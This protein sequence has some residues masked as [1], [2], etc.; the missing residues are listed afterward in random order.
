MMTV[1]TSDSTDITIN[2]LE[3]IHLTD[4]QQY[5]TFVRFFFFVS[6]NVK[7][8]QYELQFSV[9]LISFTLKEHDDVNGTVN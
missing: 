2:G 9:V 8:Q 1:Q 6:M 4:V 7:E 3:T 5:A